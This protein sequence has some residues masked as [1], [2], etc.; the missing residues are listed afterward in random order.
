MQCQSISR[1]EVANERIKKGQLEISVSSGELSVQRTHIG[2]TDIGV[3]N[4]A[5][6]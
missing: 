1:D 5:N 4:L 6:N 2:E 3:I